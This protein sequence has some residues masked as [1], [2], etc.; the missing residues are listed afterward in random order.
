MKNKF[1]F[2]LAAAALLASCGPTN[3][4]ES[5]SVVN[6]SES[7]ISSSEVV[8]EISITLDQTEVTVDAGATKTVKA[9]VTGTMN[10]NVTWSSSDDNVATVSAGTITGVAAGTAT[11]TA[12]SV[13]DPNVKA[14]V[15]VTVNEDPNKPV[16]KTIA[17]VAVATPIPEGTADKTTLVSEK[18]FIV[19]GMVVAYGEGAS[20]VYD[21]TG[22][23][24][25]FGNDAMEAAKIGEC[26]RLT[27]KT[28]TYYAKATDVRWPQ[29]NIYS[30]VEDQKA[31][32]EKIDAIDGLTAPTATEF[33][34]TEIAAYAPKNNGVYYVNTTV[35]AKASGTYMNCYIGDY[36]DR[37][38]S[39]SSDKFVP[40]D[41]VKYN[42]TGYLAEAKSDS[43]HITLYPVTWEEAGMD[44]VESLTIKAE[45]EEVTTLSM[46]VKEI[47]NLTAEIAPATADPRVTWT[48]SDE[49][50]VTVVDGVVTAVAAGTANITV[51][52]EGKNAEGAVITKTIAVTVNAEVA[53]AALPLTC[54]FNNAV[55]AGWT[56][57]EEGYDSYSPKFYK[58]GA[59]NVNF[60]KIYIDSPIFEKDAAGVDVKLVVAALNAKTGT[61][62][63]NTDD[64]TVF[65]V[66]GMNLEGDVVATD[67]VKDKDLKGPCTLN[68]SLAGDNIYSVRVYTTN[69]A[70]KDGISQNTALKTIEITG[71][72]VAAE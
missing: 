53:K 24:L 56:A 32:I 47:V 35:T 13:A 22:T 40:V 43:K 3:S 63:N 29:F 48:S 19:E 12:A 18:S 5:S 10:K 38:I 23:I 16:K 54:D 71:K 39:I 51:T 8:E 50:V 11:I 70:S 62:T 37:D 27:G 34:E 2:V 44:A 33:G 64:T 36:K 17:E 55:P 21:G 65:T 42:V 67:I 58:S 69:L 68:L 6:S 60:A 52:T 14:T 1:F 20:L 45:G 61:Q 59:L 25:A 66:T 57:A 31:T 49:K 46:G 28:T 7:E 15:A 41:G 30:K 9:T 4:S 26:V 72:T